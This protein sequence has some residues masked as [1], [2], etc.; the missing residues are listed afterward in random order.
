MS[1]KELPLRELLLFLLE[2]DI[3]L[4][5][6]NEFIFELGTRIIEQPSLL[7]DQLLQ[8]H[9]PLARAAQE[10]VRRFLVSTISTYSIFWAVSM[11]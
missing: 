8:R 5:E 9:Q 10:H 4:R 7:D 11:F 3:S 2:R 6:R 1:K